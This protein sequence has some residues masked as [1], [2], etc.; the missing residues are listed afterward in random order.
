MPKRKYILALDQGTTSSRA[1]VFDSKSRIVAVGQKEFPQ[2][3]P[4]SGWVEHDPKIIW[5]TQL[6]TAKQALRQAKLTASDIAAI[7]ITNQRETTVV[8]DRITGKPI[9]NAI[10]W[11]DRR[12]ADFCDALKKD[13][14]DRLI[15]RLTGLEL[16]AY[17]SATKINWLLKLTKGARARR[18]R[19]G[20]RLERLT[21]GSFG[22]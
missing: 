21:H 3:F 16:D 18:T 13:K 4:R 7:G 20:W 6:A 2:I 12:T 1:I 15:R 9:A 22:I 14:A 11:Q 17:F 5:K 8:W 19:G 10:V